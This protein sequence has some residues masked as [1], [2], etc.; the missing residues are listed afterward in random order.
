MQ[1]LCRAWLQ[2]QWLLIKDDFTGL[3]L[4]CLHIFLLLFEKD[5]YYKEY[6]V[7]WAGS[8]AASHACTAWPGITSETSSVPVLPKAPPHAFKWGLLRLAQRPRKGSRPLRLEKKA[9]AKKQAININ[10]PGKGEER[11]DT[12]AQK[13]WLHMALMRSFPQDRSSTE[14][15]E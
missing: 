1:N 12:G 13:E 10:A 14:N 6:L 11:K 2:D 5:A 9:T 7:D 4:D 8:A 15:T 3:W